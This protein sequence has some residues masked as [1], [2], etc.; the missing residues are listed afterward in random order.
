MRSTLRCDSSLS[1]PAASLSSVCPSSRYCAKMSSSIAIV[2]RGDGLGI[3]EGAAPSSPNLSRWSIVY[4]L[5]GRFH[6]RGVPT[7]KRLPWLLSP[8]GDR[9]NQHAVAAPTVQRCALKSLLWYTSATI[10]PL[11]TISATATQWIYLE[12]A[13][14][15]TGRLSQQCHFP[16]LQIINC[17]SFDGKYAHQV[18]KGKEGRGVH[19]PP[20]FGFPGGRF[21]GRFGKLSSDPVLYCT[22]LSVEN[23]I[24][25][26]PWYQ[27]SVLRKHGCH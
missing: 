22:V 16:P 21:L 8:L 10:P 7:K 12:T 26:H 23:P 6:Q 19:G 4:H 15:E 14:E 5:S 24:R 20:P 13:L 18:D 27:K 3:N 2:R 9:P 1:R 25:T 17:S 11:Q